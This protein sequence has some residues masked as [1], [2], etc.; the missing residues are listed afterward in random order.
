MQLHRSKVHLYRFPVVHMVAAVLQKRSTLLYVH[1]FEQPSPP[2][3]T[4]LG[5]LMFHTLPLVQSEG[6]PT[7]D[8]K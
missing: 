1:I 5:K 4:T 2:V 6:H 3:Q 7:Y 8:I